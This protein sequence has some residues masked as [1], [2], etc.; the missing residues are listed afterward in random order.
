MRLVGQSLAV[1]FVVVLLGLL[2]WDV[3]HSHGSKVAADVNAGKAV[4]APTFDKSRLDSSGNLS[5][6]SLR[7]KVVVLNFWAS[8][9]PPCNAE[10]KTLV[11]GNAQWHK[12]GVVFVGVD[13]QDLKGPARAFL[14]RYGITYPIVT[15]SGPLAARYGV[16]GQPETFFITRTGL[17]V[18][19]HIEGKVTP[20]TL[21][22]GI[23]NALKT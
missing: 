22:E 17:I 10:A 9:C 5:L 15:D 4:P 13:F 19:P 21:S 18:P 3:A 23:R 8:W 20:Q 11:A 7:G 16:I 14:K 12:K 1:G 2:V 6:T